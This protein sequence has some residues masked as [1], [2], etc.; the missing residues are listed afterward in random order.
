M[1]NN[2][3]WFWQMIENNFDK[4]LIPLSSDWRLSVVSL[5]RRWQNVQVRFF[6]YFSI[7][8]PKILFN[9]NP[10]KT[11]AL[12]GIARI[13]SSSC[14]ALFRNEKCN[15]HLPSFSEQMISSDRT[16]GIIFTFDIWRLLGQTTALT[17]LLWR[18]GFWGSQ[19]H[20]LPI[21]GCTSVRCYL[22]CWWW[23]LWS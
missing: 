1:K 20:V 8:L 12:L 15:A 7:I 2:W 17:R 5:T 11:L 23:K 6:K 9:H 10:E 21:V 18:F 14:T 19:G 16:F 22:W 3:K 13:L 4:W